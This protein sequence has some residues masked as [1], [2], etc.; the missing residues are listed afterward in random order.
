MSRPDTPHLHPGA[1]ALVVLGGIVGTALREA[2]TLALGP[3]GAQ[4][5]ALLVCNVSGAF[6]LGLLL[7]SLA[8]RGADSGPRRAKRLLLGTGVLGGYTSYSALAL[9]VTTSGGLSATALT[10]GLGSVV[11]GLLATVLGVLAAGLVPRPR[12]VAP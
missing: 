12:E 10:Y 2:L 5:L 3:P 4:P 9:A 11:A 7:E 1:I 8:R 6:A